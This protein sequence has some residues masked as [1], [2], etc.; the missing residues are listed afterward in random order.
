MITFGKRAVVN[1]VIT[2][3]VFI[4]VFLAALM[5]SYKLF[6]SA[7]TEIQA[8][9]E[10]PAIAKQASTE[11]KEKFLLFDTGFIILWLALWIGAL[12]SAQFIDVHP[13]WFALS[14]I[15]MIALFVGAA[16]F[17][18]F[19]QEF[20]GSPSLQTDITDFPKIVWFL[21][22]M[23]KIIVVMGFS[24]AISLYSKMRASG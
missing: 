22:N 24:I 4:A 11:V 17:V 13:V 20:Y 9:D 3:M 10:L 19:L 8:M 7:D 12:I 6:K 15:V 16:P 1:D 23:Y 14:I 5:F 2:I 18:Y 21:E